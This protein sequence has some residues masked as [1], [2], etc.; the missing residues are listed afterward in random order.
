MTD[1]QIFEV[2]GAVRDSILGLDSKDV[3]FTVVGPKSFDDMVSILTGLGFK[4]FKESPETLTAVAKVP[5]SMPELQA[6][7][8]VADFV[9]ARKESSASSGR[10][11]DVIEPGS[12]FDDLSR[13]D[14]TVNAMARDPKTNEIIDPF[15]GQTDLQGSGNLRFVG[16][17]MTRIKE[18]PLRIARG[19]RFLVMKG[20][21]CEGNTW[22]ALT[23]REAAGLLSSLRPTDGKRV[24]AVDR[25]R[26]EM[27]RMFMH[28]TISSLNLMAMLPPHTR[29]ALFPEG[30]R[31]KATMEAGPAKKALDLIPGHALDL[32]VK[33]EPDF[34][35]VLSERW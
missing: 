33:S 28:D 23:S 3:D 8:K 26:S 10:M 21:D 32:R 29:E 13:R 18:D 17:P 4:V 14:F 22:D 7:T 25:L 19:F 31:L 15:G 16:D 27:D 20:F 24:V 9:F 1:I 30:L 5:D 2:G 12:L 6:R 11:P 35:E 34:R